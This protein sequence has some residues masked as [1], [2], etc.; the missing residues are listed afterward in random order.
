MNKNLSAT[1]GYFQDLRY[2]LFNACKS[3]SAASIT[4]LIAKVQNDIGGSICNHIVIYGTTR[5]LMKEQL[6]VLFVNSIEQ[7][8]QDTPLHIAASVG[9]AACVNALIAAGADVNAKD[10]SGKTPLHVAAEWACLECMGALI[11]AG[12]DVNA[13]D[14]FGNIPLH[15]AVSRISSQANCVVM[16]IDNGSRLDEKNSEGATPLYWAVWRGDTC[17]VRVLIERGANIHERDNNDNT[18]LHVPRN[19]MISPYNIHVDNV[20]YLLTLPDIDMQATNNDGRTAEGAATERGL[21]DLA[22]KIR[23]AVAGTHFWSSRQSRSRSG[24][25]VSLRSR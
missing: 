17:C 11:A 16:L 7:Y 8:T 15:W 14:H 18:L 9:S 1:Q 25:T 13:K 10:R 19:T 4:N 5:A 6:V 3:G 20:R 12:G 22:D 21:V 2:D 23:V 24:R